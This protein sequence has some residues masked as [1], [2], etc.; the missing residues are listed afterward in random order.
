MSRAQRRF[1]KL[2][3]KAR[4]RPRDFANKAPLAHPH[5]QTETSRSRNSW[6]NNCEKIAD[7]T[8]YIKYNQVDNVSWPKFKK[9]SFGPV[10]D[11]G[12]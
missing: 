6:K 7:D 11:Q 9:E 2:S 5:T 4:P 10:A 1:Y 12:R 8:V 3:I